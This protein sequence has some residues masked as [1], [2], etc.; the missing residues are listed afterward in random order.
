MWSAKVLTFESGKA[1]WRRW[2]DRHCNLVSGVYLKN[3]NGMVR[4]REGRGSSWA[5]E[6]HGTDEGEKGGPR[7]ITNGICHNLLVGLVSLHL[8]V[9]QGTGRTRVS[10]SWPVCVGA[11]AS[12]SAGGVCITVPRGA[13]DS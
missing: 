4:R 5:W 9:S 13:C 10:P 2:G 12:D 6:S 3:R 8:A 7:W 11:E 1:P